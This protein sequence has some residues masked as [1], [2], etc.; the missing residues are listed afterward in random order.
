M[1]GEGPHIL[2]AGDAVS[3]QKMLGDV[4]KG[5]MTASLLL[6]VAPHLAQQVSDL[7]CG[8]GQPWLHQQGEDVAQKVR[9]TLAEE[10]LA[11]HEVEIF[12][13]VVDVLT[14]RQV[15]PLDLLKYVGSEREEVSYSAEEKEAHALRH[16]VDTIHRVSEY[17]REY[18][19]WTEVWEHHRPRTDEEIAAHAEVCD[20]C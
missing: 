10:W 5:K 6:E 15:H 7:L 11:D 17:L 3:V 8:D 19:S 16:L 4:A 9:D 20:C 13:Q 1:V 2:P 18:D 14:R 12:R